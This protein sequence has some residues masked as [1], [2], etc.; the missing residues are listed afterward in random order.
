MKV[1]NCC[2][3]PDRMITPDGPDY[4]DTGI[5]PRCKEHCVFEEDDDEAS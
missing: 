2:G 4:S 3:E 5:C 1:S